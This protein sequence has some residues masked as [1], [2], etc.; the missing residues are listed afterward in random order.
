MNLW[1]YIS[2]SLVGT[3]FPTSCLSCGVEN[4]FICPS[5]L[6]QRVLLDK[7][8]LPPHTTALFSY[9]DPVIKK[10]LWYLKYKNISRIAEELSPFLYDTCQ[11]ISHENF[12]HYGD[13]RL[14][15]IPIPLYKSKEKKRGYNQSKLLVK[16]I[17]KKQKGE[18]IFLS[19]QDTV[20][21]K[22]KD[23]TS[24]TKQKSKKERLAN[25]QNSFI[26]ENKDLIKG[27][28]ILLVDDIVT[29][30]AT[31]EEARRILLRAGARSVSALAVAH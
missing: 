28:H 8:T 7:G 6:T 3:L 27:K 17:I 9:R 22:T 5:C 14:L 18:N 30:G 15:L 11:E 31:I 23:T 24:Q 4:L 1:S 16:S 13:P 29:T 20:L 19:Y 21:V 25:I 2:Q 12:L 26:V 10:I